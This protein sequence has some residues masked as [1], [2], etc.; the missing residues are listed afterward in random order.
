MDKFKIR[1]AKKYPKLFGKWVGDAEG[2]GIVVPGHGDRVR[3]Q[4]MKLNP[5]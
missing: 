1:S 4:Q 2:K 3:Q 5:V